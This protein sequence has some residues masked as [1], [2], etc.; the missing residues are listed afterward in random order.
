MEAALWIGAAL[1]GLTIFIAIVV[2]IPTP[3]ED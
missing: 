1:I 3:E 2:T